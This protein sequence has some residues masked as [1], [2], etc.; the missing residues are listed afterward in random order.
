VAL[1]RTCTLNA[2]AKNIHVQKS[3]PGIWREQYQDFQADS[4]HVNGIENLFRAEIAAG[5]LP[6]V[7]FLSVSPPSF[8]NG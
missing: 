4:W 7:C 8:L 3:Q 6:A 5:E 2:G 1:L